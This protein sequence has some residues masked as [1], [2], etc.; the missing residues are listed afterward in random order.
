MRYNSARLSARSGAIAAWC[1]ECLVW[2]MV[3]QVM[4]SAALPWARVSWC[5]LWWR[6]CSGAPPPPRPL[7]P[8]SG[9]SFTLSSTAPSPPPTPPHPP[10][11]PCNDGQH[12]CP[13][14]RHSADGQVLCRSFPVCLHKPS[15]CTLQRMQR[16][17]I[18]WIDCKIILKILLYCYIKSCVN[19]KV[20]I[21]GRKRV[22]V[23]NPKLMTASCHFWLSSGG[24]QKCRRTHDIQEYW[25]KNE[26][27]FWE[28][29]FA[30]GQYKDKRSILIWEQNLAIFHP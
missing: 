1:H 6:L 5:Q 15:W 28:N 14:S 4:P 17:R 23:I 9:A 27:Q 24:G 10:C 12:T 21:R 18:V 20:I 30:K 26:P 22:S 29:L 11:P 3:Y 16:C 19:C 7:V 25:L 2:S 13:P 8:L